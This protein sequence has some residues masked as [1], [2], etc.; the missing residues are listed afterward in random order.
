MT[1]AIYIDCHA[2]IAG[3]MFLAALVDLG[4]DPE[5]ITAELQKLPI[6]TFDLSFTKQVKQGINAQTLTIDFTEAHHHRKA[7][8]IYKL[9]T[10]STLPERVKTRSTQIFTEIAQAE[11]KIHGMSVEEVHFHEVGAMDSIIDIIGCCLALE[12][13]NIDSIYCSAIPTGHGRIHI[14]HGIYPVPAPATLEILTGIPLA[15][16]DVESELT[17]PTGAAI[18]K[19]LASH[20][21]PM[22]AI[23]PTNIAYGTGTKDFDF[24][25]VLRLVQFTALAA[26]QDTVQVLECQIDDMTG[27]TLGDF[28]DSVL[29]KGALDVYYT[30]I[31]MKKNRP[32]IA[33]T[34]ICELANKPFFEDYLLL[35]T[36]TLGVRSSTVQRRVLERDF[37]TLSTQYGDIT[38]KIAKLGSKTIKIKPEFSDMRRIAHETG[39][40]LHQLYS[41]ISAEIHQHYGHLN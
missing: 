34:V 8:D 40:P 15:N 4:A 19:S 16:F 39:Q 26:Q 31:S 3:D 23:T 17:T 38:I 12:N 36:T 5:Y 28:L 30:P 1:Q 9:I 24:P 37:D 27:E 21:G 32:A 35:H 18:V 41:E 33:L 29:A 7:A 13:L 10:E 11:A 6:D 22:P 2:G 14:A 20:F 25:N